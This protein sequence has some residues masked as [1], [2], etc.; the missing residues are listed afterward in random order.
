M[1][2]WFAFVSLKQ[3]LSYAH[4]SYLFLKL[5]FW[6]QVRV[7]S[8][9]AAAVAISSTVLA[10]AE[11]CYISSWLPLKATNLSNTL[12]SLT[13][14]NKNNAT[15]MKSFVEAL[16]KNTALVKAVISCLENELLDRIN[17]G[18]ICRNHATNDSKMIYSSFCVQLSN[19]ILVCFLPSL[20]P[21]LITQ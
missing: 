3:L 4:T 15:M 21:F 16:H 2:L 13:M 8:A 12:S 6:T 20:F 1:W 10:N 19:K 18:R 5:P 11:K 7:Y 14:T 17:F 9:R